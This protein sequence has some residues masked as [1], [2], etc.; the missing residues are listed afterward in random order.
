MTEPRNHHYFFAHRF[1]PQV[2]FE[3]P[4]RF[5]DCLV[6]DGN[7]FLLWLWEQCAAYLEQSE[8]LAPDGLSFALE[9]LKD[10]T[11]AALIEMPPPTG[12]AETYFVAVAYQPERQRLQQTR[13]GKTRYFTLEF[14]EAFDGRARTVLGEWTSDGN[15]ANFGDG[16]M[17]AREAFLND[18]IRLLEK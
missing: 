11:V 10:D 17:A 5:F 16:P 2:A 3:N 12:V 4:A 13:L 1:L 14:S 15:H 8:H 18:V 7:D 9:R 6:A